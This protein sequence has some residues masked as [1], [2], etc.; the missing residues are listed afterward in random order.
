MLRAPWLEWLAKI[1]NALMEPI[2]LQGKETL[3]RE[4]GRR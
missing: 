4:E 2:T 1:D 3:K